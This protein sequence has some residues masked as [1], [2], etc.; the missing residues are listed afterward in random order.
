[1]DANAAL[2]FLVDS[3]NSSPEREPVASELGGSLLLTHLNQVLTW[4]AVLQSIYGDD[5]IHVREPASG[6]YKEGTT[7]RYEVS[8]KR[9]H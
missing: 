4:A 9:V 5:A 6:T 7:L 8:L 2:D 1:M 3:L